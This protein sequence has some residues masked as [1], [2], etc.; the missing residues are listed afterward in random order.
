M[1]HSLAPCGC[2]KAGPKRGHPIFMPRRGRSKRLH[3]PRAESV[4]SALKDAILDPA[5]RVSEQ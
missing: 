2:G 5:H 3:S 4:H 1:G